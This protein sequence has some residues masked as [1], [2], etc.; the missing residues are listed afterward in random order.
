MGPTFPVYSDGFLKKLGKKNSKKRKAL[1][2]AIRR[3]LKA[4]PN[5]KVVINVIKKA[6]ATTMPTYK[7][8]LTSP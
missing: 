6:K 2:A 7:K 4:D 5:H 3:A 8:L 1:K